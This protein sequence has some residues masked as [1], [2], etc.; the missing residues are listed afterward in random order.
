MARLPDREIIRLRK[1]VAVMRS[2]LNRQ[3]MGADL[4]QLH[5]SLGWVPGAWATARRFAPF[6]ALL[7]PLALR[8]KTPGRFSLKRIAA[9]GVVGWRLLKKIRTLW[10]RP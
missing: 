4:Q 8:A 2:E 5:A 9:G 6:L 3:R 7:T 1:Q 10:K